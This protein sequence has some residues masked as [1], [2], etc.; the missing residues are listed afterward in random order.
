MIVVFGSANID[1]ILPIPHL[2][3]PGETVLA[4]E[5]ATAA[6]G[7]GSNQAIAASRAGGPVAFVGCVGRDG[8]G[9]LL[10][11]KLTSAGVG[12]AG[13]RRVP[14][15]TGTAII[16][17][18]RA[19]RN[20]ILV[21]S[22]ANALARATQ[23]PERWLGPSTLLVLQMEVA[24]R[25]NWRLLRRAKARGA[26]VLLNL[27]PAAPVPASVLR[28][29]DY[30]V[31]NETEALALAKSVGRRVVRPAAAAKALALHCGGVVIATLGAKGAIAIARE[32]TLR[33]PAPAIRP[34]DTTGA[35]DAFVGAFAAA[36]DR[37]ESIEAALRYGVA[38]GSL[39]CL[40]RGAEPS[41]PKAA[42]IATLVRRMARGDRGKVGKRR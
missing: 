7:K 25:E 22:G 15:A 13:L 39:A 29:V 4:D 1:L 41:L 33:V 27:A 37:A 19:G 3:E 2:P 8:Y 40:V 10:A 5:L 23:V 31:V 24:A 36:L 34:I 9:A 42:G 20:T 30:L 28:K 38:A 6:G 32:G 21:A 18:D 16:A 35:G 17:L 14:A 12:I 26:R 11:A